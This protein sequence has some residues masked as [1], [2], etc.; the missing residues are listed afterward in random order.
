MNRYAFLISLIV[1]ACVHAHNNQE[2]F[3]QAG[4]LYALQEYAQANDTYAQIDSNGTAVWFNRARA[5]MRA[6]QSDNAR[7]YLMRARKYA[8]SRQLYNFVAQE[9]RKLF[10]QPVQPTVVES[11]YDMFVGVSR[12]FSLLFLQLLFLCLLY[13]GTL[14]WLPLWSPQVYSRWSLVMLVPTF[15]SACLLVAAY[16]DRQQ[17]VTVQR[18]VH[19]RA[20]KHDSFSA[21][22]S[23]HQ[24]DIAR[25]ERAQD[26]WLQVV[27]Q[28]TRG[29]VRTSDVITI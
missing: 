5:S 26:E 3:L 28:G 17:Q 22:A 24:G 27:H 19:M 16:Y 18:E 8:P 12:G 15:F 1:T 6:G 14:L 2:L 10:A 25:V 9:Q 21:V 20:G 13:L 11:M 4:E 7:L 29:W 23:L